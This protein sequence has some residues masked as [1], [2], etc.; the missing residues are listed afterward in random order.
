MYSREI[1]HLLWIHYFKFGMI[2]VW[3]N[4]SAQ[5]VKVILFYL[6]MRYSISCTCIPLLCEMSHSIVTCY[7]RL[8]VTRTD[9]FHEFAMESGKFYE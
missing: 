8:T 7:D 9:T 4:F 6:I 5:K 2:W 3:K 1:T